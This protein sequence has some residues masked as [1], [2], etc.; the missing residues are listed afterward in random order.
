MEQEERVLWEKLIDSIS[1]A[2][3]VVWLTTVLCVFGLVT[4]LLFFVGGLL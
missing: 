1:T 3:F 4:T 2:M